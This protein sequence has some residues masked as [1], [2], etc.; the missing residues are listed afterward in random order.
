MSGFIGALIPKDK[1][2]LI[3]AFAFDPLQIEFRINPHAMFTSGFIGTEDTT[4]TTKAAHP[5]FRSNTL[6]VQMNRA[7]WRIVEFAIEVDIL[8]FSDEVNNIVKSQL[9]STDGIV[10]HSNSYSLGPIWTFPNTIACTDPF[11]VNLGF[12]SL[13]AIV[14]C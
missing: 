1:Y 12:E 6:G 5:A 10:F 4:A 3:P 13:K 9:S 7:S 14:L 11:S 2:K 8:Q